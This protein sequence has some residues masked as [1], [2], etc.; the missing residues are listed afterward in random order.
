MKS[1]GLKA[2]MSQ[3][4]AASEESGFVPFV[5]PPSPRLWRASFVVKE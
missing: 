3:A 4:T 1:K 5:F 2:P